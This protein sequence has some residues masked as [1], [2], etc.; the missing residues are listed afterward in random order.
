[1]EGWGTVW[2]RK[3]KSVSQEARLDNIKDVECGS[4]SGNIH[5]FLPEL[6][7]FGYDENEHLHIVILEL[8]HLK[9]NLG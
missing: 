5:C 1:M 7:R 2:K 3:K 4:V 6:P 9:V 8:L